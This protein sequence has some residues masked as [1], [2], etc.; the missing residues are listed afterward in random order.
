[1]GF[2]RLSIY[3]GL[4]ATSGSAAYLAA[5]NPVIAPLPSSDP[6]WKSA[7]YKCHNPAGNPATQDVCIKRI[8]LSKIRPELLEKEGDLALEFCRGVW[9]GLG[10]FSW[11]RRRYPD[12]H[13]VGYVIQRKYLE[14]KWKG[15][16]T[17]QQLW[18]RSQLAQGTYDRGTIITDH[19]EVV[20]KTPTTI[21]VRCGDSPRNQGLRPSDGL[22][23]ISAIVDEERE[24]VELRL[25]SCLFSSQGSTTGAKGPMPAWKEELHQWYARIWSETGS[26]RLLK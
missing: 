24:E 25:R 18:T 15:P 7:I 10:E 11:T 5:R 12:S 23:S 3:T 4:L 16:E 22:F 14:M 17:S 26:W 9:G 20:E 13:Y 19:F 2:F 8:P 1:M 6:I 21:T